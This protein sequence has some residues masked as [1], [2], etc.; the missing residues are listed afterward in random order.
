[1]HE[2]MRVVPPPTQPVDGDGEWRRVWASLGCQLPSDYQDLVHQYGL[3]SFD[4]VVLWTP[5]TGS[6]WANLVAQARDLIANYAPLRDDCP[7]DF[8]YP[9]YP[10]HGGLLPWASTGDGDWLCWLTGGEPDRWPVVEW[11]I[12][13]GAHRHDAGTVEFLYGYLSG[14]REAML[15]RPPPPVPW[16]DPYRERVQVLVVLT[17]GATPPADRYQRLRACFGPTVDRAVW[18]GGDGNRQDTFKALDHDWLVTY[19]QG[20]AHSVWVDCPPA[21]ADNARAILQGA[22]AAMGCQIRPA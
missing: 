7:E 2:L 3:G 19:N 17:G 10:E 21:D 11:N 22:A 9:L 5:F 15:L 6:S 8:P 12:R 16:F 14:E 13:E 18:D 1:M 20:S 4:D